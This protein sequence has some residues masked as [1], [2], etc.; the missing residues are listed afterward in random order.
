MQE[1]LGVTM[2]TPA[3]CGGRGRVCPVDL[4]RGGVTDQGPVAAIILIADYYVKTCEHGQEKSL[5][6]QK[7][8]ALVG[9][10]FGGSERGPLVLG[11]EG[12]GLRH[13]RR[14]HGDRCLF[15]GVG[16]VGLAAY[17]APAGTPCTA[18]ALFHPRVKR[19]RTSWNFSNLLTN[20]EVG[21]SRTL[22]EELYA[23]WATGPRWTSDA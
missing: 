22:E 20:K 11:R 16:L 13:S 19:E 9:L 18:A 23:S 5:E 12:E 6:L 17:S 1:E 2:Y 3:G 8:G 7:G 15:G 4:A 10:P 14:L 21:T